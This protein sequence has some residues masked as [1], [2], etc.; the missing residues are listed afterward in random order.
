MRQAL[1]PLALISTVTAGAQ[2][3]NG[4][5]ENGTTGWNVPCECAPASFSSDGAPGSGSQCIGLENVHLDCE[6]MLFSAVEQAT[7]WLTPGYWHFSGWIKSAV[8]GD[9][10]GSRIALGTGPFSGISVDL[11]SSAGQWEYKELMVPLDASADLANMRVSLVPDDGNEQPPTLCYF[12]NIQLTQVINTG[13]TDRSLRS[14]PF[15]PNPATD[16]LWID[17]TETPTAITC[18]DATGRKVPLPTFRHTGSTLEVDVSS[19]PPGLSVM[20]M[21]TASGV[22]TLRFIKA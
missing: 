10:P 13:I 15:R 17:L 3:I 2:L 16:R 14:P 11:W 6:C 7:P 19:V 9:V 4:S 12:D 5:F 8:Q 1:L 18:V 22:R 21:K 20:L